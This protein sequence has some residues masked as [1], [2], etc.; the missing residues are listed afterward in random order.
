MVCWHLTRI[1]LTELKLIVE[2]YK[3]SD[4]RDV[5]GELVQLKRIAHCGLGAEPL[6]TGVL[7]GLGAKPSAAGRLFA[8]LWEKIILMPLDHISHMFRAI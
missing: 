4:L 5:L 2:K 3:V 8:T 6:A 7:G 1:L